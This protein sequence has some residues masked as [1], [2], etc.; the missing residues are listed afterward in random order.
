MRKKSN[1]KEWLRW[2]KNNGRVKK[3]EKKIMPKSDLRWE[4]NNGR[5]KKDG[6]KI[7]PKS[8]DANSLWNIVQQVGP[9]C[10]TNITH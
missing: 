1:A 10:W 2:E 9:T 7:M 8:T 5:V 4:K 6:K 3:D